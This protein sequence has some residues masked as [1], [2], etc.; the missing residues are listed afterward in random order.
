MAFLPFFNYV[1]VPRTVKAALALWISILFFPVVPKITFQIT[2]LNLVLAIFNEVAFAFFTGAALNMVFDIL[3]YAGEQISFIMGFTLANVIDPNF[4]E[5]ITII[6][7]FFTWVAV[8]VF[9]SFGGD[10]L[11]IY[12]MSYLMQKMPF[13]AFFAYK[14]VY[15]YFVHFMYQYFLLGMGMAF[16]VIA[17]SLMSDIIFGMIMKTMPQFNLL[18]VGF[19]IKIALA[20]IVLIMIIGSMM[21]VFHVEMLHAFEA[22]SRFIG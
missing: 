8:L 7:R 13:G 21:D 10:H 6:S 12:L 9:F 3:R 5:N 1:N 19:P 14:S 18:V 15:K 22:V 4:G 20:F 17:I 11:E 16:P 2:L